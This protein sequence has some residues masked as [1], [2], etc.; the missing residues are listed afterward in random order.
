MVARLREEGE[1]ERQ[2]KK[3]DLQTYFLAHL[4]SPLQLGRAWSSG[5]SGGPA[6]GAG[7]GAQGWEQSA[8]SRR[9]RRPATI[10]AAAAAR[11]A[12][13][14]GRRRG[15]ARGGPAPLIL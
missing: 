11:A 3:R 2:R 4:T 8:P 6:G 15:R 7:E 9:R 12:V 5:C 13:G 14:A 10:E 1:K